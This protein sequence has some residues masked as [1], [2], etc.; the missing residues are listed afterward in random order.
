MNHLIDYNIKA[1]LLLMVLAVSAFFTQFKETFLLT[2][3][4]SV[5][6]LPNTER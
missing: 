6:M 2:T 1:A 3:H 5:V 4:P